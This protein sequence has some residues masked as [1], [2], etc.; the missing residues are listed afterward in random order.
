MSNAA[1]YASLSP[2]AVMDAV[3]STG[4][5]T[6]GRLLALNS[7]E[8]RVYQVGVED[9]SPIV[10][11]FYRAARWSDAAI[12]EEHAFAVELAEAE[13]PVV[14]PLKVENSTLQHHGGF[15]FALYPRQGGRAPELESTDNLAWVGRLLARM[16]GV[17]SRGRFQARG[18]IDRATFIEAPS[19]VVLASALLPEAVRDRYA[20]A[21]GELDTLIAERWARVDALSTLRLHG[22]CHAG[23]V[24][25]TDSGPHF[26]DLDD[27]RSGPA[28]QDLWMLATNPRA[29]DA[30]LEGYEEFRDFDR[31]E[32]ALIEPLRLMRQIHYAGWIAQRWDDPAFPRAFPFASEPRWWEQHVEDLREAASSLA[33]SA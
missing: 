22:D 10:A 7:F 20:R 24:L 19:K 9:S 11:K 17:G 29:M 3:E 4:V 26:V 30:L 5:L 32:L 1:P 14:A 15:R 21:I 25:W 12:L 23:N 16:H 31:R 8:N 2:D 13:L 33:G 18:T 6:D 27:A 28:V